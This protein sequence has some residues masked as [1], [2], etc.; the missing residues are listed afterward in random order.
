MVLYG[1]IIA[2]ACVLSVG[3]GLLCAGND[4]FSAV[5]LVIAYTLLIPI[6]IV[7]TPVAPTSATKQRP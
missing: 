7:R 6:A 5:L 1:W 2:A 3:Y 4:S